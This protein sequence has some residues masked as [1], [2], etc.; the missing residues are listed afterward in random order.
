MIVR[1]PTK[2]NYIIYWHVLK[3]V[4]IFF[5]IFLTV[6]GLVTKWKDS[7]S[8][9][10]CSTLSEISWT[11]V[12]LDGKKNVGKDKLMRML[13]SFTCPPKQIAICTHLIRFNTWLWLLKLLD[14][15][16]WRHAKSLQSCL[17]LCDA[18][19]CS[20]PGSSIHRDSPGK[21]TGVSCHALLQGIFPL[22]CLKSTLSFSLISSLKTLGYVVDTL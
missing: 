14:C 5:L 9:S 15:L 20:P 6:T 21:N 18:M 17:T 3:K 10:S 13:Q 11:G 4:L 16:A 7:L 19:D 12:Y 2:K 22:D 1:K 8:A